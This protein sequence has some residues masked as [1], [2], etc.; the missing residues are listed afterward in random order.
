MA[1]RSMASNKATARRDLFGELIEGTGALKASRGGKRTLRIPSNLAY[2]AR[3]AGSDI[4]PNAPLIF[5]VELLE[6]K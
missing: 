1:K 4:P 5:D 3:G 6:V 2:G